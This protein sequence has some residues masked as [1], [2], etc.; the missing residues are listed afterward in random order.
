MIASED[1]MIHKL[2]VSMLVLS[3]DNLIQNE[4]PGINFHV[5]VAE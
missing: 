1:I 2:R 4:R 3:F 5:H